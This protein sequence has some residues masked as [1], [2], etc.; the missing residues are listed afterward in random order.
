MQQLLYTCKKAE[1]RRKHLQQ[2]LRDIK[3]SMADLDQIQERCE[4]QIQSLTACSKKS[5]TK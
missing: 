5:G 3:A 4:K 1:E 2:Q